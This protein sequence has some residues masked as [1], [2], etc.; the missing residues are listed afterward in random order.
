MVSTQKQGIHTIN[1]LII[2]NFFNGDLSNAVSINVFLQLFVSFEQFCLKIFEIDHVVVKIIS[3][4]FN[5]NLFD[6]SHL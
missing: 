4:I 3:L 6:F 1:T 2:I 5:V